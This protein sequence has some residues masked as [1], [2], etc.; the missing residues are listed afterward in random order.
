MATIVAK[1]HLKSASLEC[2]MMSHHALAGFDAQSRFTSCE[3]SCFN[4]ADM[5]IQSKKQPNP[6]S[7]GMFLH[8]PGN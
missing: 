4:S 6:H 1:Y 2:V 7:A 8:G 5:T 3:Q